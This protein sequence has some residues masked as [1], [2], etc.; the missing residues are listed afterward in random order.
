MVTAP[1]LADFTLFPR[2]QK[3][4]I[5]MV[6]VRQVQT[7]FRWYSDRMID[8]EPSHIHIT[9]RKRELTG[10]PLMNEIYRYGESRR[11]AEN[12]QAELSGDGASNQP[13]QQPVFESPLYPQTD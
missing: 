5:E 6:H 2:C 4:V 10:T 1:S 7:L 3:D 11:A 13:A 8:H 12:N 9:L